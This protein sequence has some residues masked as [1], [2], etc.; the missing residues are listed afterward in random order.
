MNPLRSVV[1]AL[2][3]FALSTGAM[4]DVTIN[5]VGVKFEP[6][7]AYVQ[8]GESVTWTGMD[9]HNVETLSAMIPEG[10]VEFNTAVGENVTET[11]DT[12]GIYVY[13]CTPHWGTR[14]GGVVVVGE[15]E[16][17]SE[18][19]EAYLAA[20]EEDRANLLPAKGLIKKA[21]KDMEANGLM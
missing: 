2:S 14:M 8:P 3:T 1:F 4:A 10:G 15:P 9:S 16:N 6:L 19:L 12:P 21:G 7:V 11:F 20:I 5:A 18:I 13:K 17:A